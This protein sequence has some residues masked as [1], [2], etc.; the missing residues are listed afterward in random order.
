MSSASST[1][2]AVADDHG[3]PRIMAGHVTMLLDVLEP[4]ESVRHVAMARLRNPGV[5]ELAKGLHDPR[6]LVGSGAR[7]LNEALGGVLAVTDRRIV[8]LARTLMGRGKVAAGNEYISVGLSDV[9]GVRSKRGIGTG[10]VRKVLSL[11]LRGSQLWVRLDGGEAEFM[12]IKPLDAAQ[13]M[14]QTIRSAR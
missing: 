7:E 12:E 1:A 2:A 9:R 8:Y 5:L 3:L 4:G 14:E 13:A 10:D 6:K 11:T